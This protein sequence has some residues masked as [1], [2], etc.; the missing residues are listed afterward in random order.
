MLIPFPTF[1][2]YLA[3]IVESAGQ[4][5]EG[6]YAMAARSLRGIHSALRRIRHSARHQQLAD[7]VDYALQA[8][9]RSDHEVA[10]SIVLRAAELLARDRGGDL[11][12]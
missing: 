5:H 12:G 6:D 3:L 2:S 1:E 4:L 11:A 9:N 10:I 7:F 8:G